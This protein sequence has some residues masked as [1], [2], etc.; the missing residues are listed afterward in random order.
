MVATFLRIINDINE[1]IVSAYADEPTLF[2]KDVD[3]LRRA[4]KVLVDF[5]G[6]SGL[7]INLD[8]S[9]LLAL[10]SYRESPPD[11]AGTGLKFCFEPVKLLGVTFTTDLDNME[12][13]NYVPKFEEL[14]TILRIWSMRDMAPMGRITVI[15]SLG[16]P[17][18]IYLLSV[19]PKPSDAFLKELDSVLYK[20]I[21]QNKPDKVS[22]KTIIGI[23]MKEV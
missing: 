17:Q 2:L 3:S 16:L 22:R 19:L 7:T 5:K 4:I 21:W 11:I 12:K 1:V 6:Y 14:K 15:K 8:K 18:L 10:G 13:L 9:V 23:I 20:F